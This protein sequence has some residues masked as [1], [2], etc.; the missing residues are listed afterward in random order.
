M[1]VF[2]KSSMINIMIGYKKSEKI[3]IDIYNKNT[4]SVREVFTFLAPSRSSISIGPPGGPEAKTRG[5]I[6]RNRY[7]Y[8]IIDDN[9]HRSY[10]KNSDSVP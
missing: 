1:R 6:V 5:P 10:Y 3:D 2:I 7:F 8:K 9:Y 4:H